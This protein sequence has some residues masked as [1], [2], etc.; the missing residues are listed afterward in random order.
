MTTTD[1]IFIAFVV[2]ILGLNSLY[3]TKIAYDTAAMTQDIREI[4]S[5]LRDSNNCLAWPD[6]ACL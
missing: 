3:Q 5:E 1:R 6:A 2:L 4:T